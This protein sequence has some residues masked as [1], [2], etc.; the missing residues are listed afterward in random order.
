MPQ[1]MGQGVCL[2]RSYAHLEP[3][4]R[5]REMF[6]KCSTRPA[7]AAPPG[8]LLERW[9][10]GPYVRLTESGN[11]GMGPTSSVVTGRSGDSDEC[12]SWKNHS[13]KESKIL[14]L[15]LKDTFV[16]M[17]RL[18]Y[19]FFNS[20]LSWFIISKYVDIGCVGLHSDPYSQMFG[21]ANVW[22]GYV[23]L[24][25]SSQVVKWRYWG[26]LDDAVG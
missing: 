9:L 16:K 13:S 20:L 1:R 18:E 7:V 15:N 11:L 23:S 6:S 17:G 2:P 21:P 4:P 10:L 12:P 22:D 8:I 24:S 3:G 26:H 5:S 14:C 19:I 25:Q